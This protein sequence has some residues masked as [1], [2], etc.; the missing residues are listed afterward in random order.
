MDKD[1]EILCT[2]CARGQSQGVPG[3]NIKVI[4]GLPLIAHTIKQAKEVNIFDNI[5]VSTESTQIAE[6][7]KKYGAE[8][9]F[10]RPEELANSKIAKYPAIR[11]AITSCE[12]IFSKTYDFIIDLDPTSPLRDL[13]DI[14]ECVNILKNKEVEN[15][16]TAMPSRRSPYFN[17]IERDDE[18]FIDLSKRISPLPSCR[19]DSPLCYDMNAS[20]YG[21]KRSVLFENEIP[22]FLKTT[23]LHVM[24]EERSIDIDS[25]LDFEFVEYLLT[26]NNSKIRND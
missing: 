2:I 18:G 13:D 23:H 26:K 3:K 24:P 17:L 16:I 9:P 21:W 14:L 22:I 7:A 25:D 6:I 5:V 12:K 8:V 15:V 19:Q 11:H 4:A 20:I 10:L 1:L